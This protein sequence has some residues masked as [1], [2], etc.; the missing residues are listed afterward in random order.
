M[1]FRLLFV[2]TLLTGILLGAAACNPGHVIL[3]GRVKSYLKVATDFKA[4]K[5][6]LTPLMKEAVASYG[7]GGDSTAMPGAAPMLQQLGAEA[8]SKVGSG[9]IEIQGRGRWAR[10]TIFVPTEHGNEPV[11]T[12]WLKLG[13]TW[14]LFSGSGGEVNKYGEPPYFAN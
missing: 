8:L 3:E 5:E 2:G 10:V 12:I 14:Y 9:N 7:S 1:T 13:T 11:P 4:A 6:F